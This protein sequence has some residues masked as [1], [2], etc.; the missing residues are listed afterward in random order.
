VP[1]VFDYAI[2][3]V[4]PRVDRGE[5]VNVGVVLHCAT[6]DWLGCRVTSDLSRVHA[7]APDLDL[8]A[9]AD[10][11]HALERIC[12]GDPTAGA[13]ASLPV[14]ERFHWLVHPRSTTI[15]MS[16]VHSGHADDPEAALTHLFA[17][18]VSPP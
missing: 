7:L 5:R 17:T 4:V 18:L 2:V 10:H 13:V 6:R 9:I 1:D 11:L 8:D 12:G 14:R 3:R 15:Q 16:A